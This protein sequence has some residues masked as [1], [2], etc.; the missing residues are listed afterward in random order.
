[1]YDDKGRVSRDYLAAY[2]PDFRNAPIQT[3]I[4]FHN[5]NDELHAYRQFDAS[6]A[7]IYEQ[8]QGRYFNEDILF[9][10][11]EHEFADYQDE[12]S[13]VF[14]TYLACFEMLPTQL[15]QYM[16]PYQSV[17]KQHA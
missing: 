5:Y 8:C 16:H 7:L 10:I 14:N 13:E 15:V 11:E 4:N 17:L 12:T 1:M 6:G 2:L 9:S 3:L